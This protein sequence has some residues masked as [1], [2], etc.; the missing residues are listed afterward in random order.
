MK[1]VTIMDIAKQVNVSKTTVSMV[2][3]NK[4]INVLE[5]TRDK[6]LKA[7]KDLNYI[8]NSLARTLSTNRS[9]TIGCIV[10]DIEN[11]FFSEIAKAIETEAEDCGFSMILCNTLNREEKEEHY[12]K[13]LISKLV[14]GVIIVPSKYGTNSLD[15]LIRNNVPFVVVDRKVKYKEKYNVVHCNNKQGIKLGIEYLIGKSK[16]NLAFVGGIR[17]GVDTRLDYFKE[18]A[19]KLEILNEDIIEEENFSMNGGIRATEKIIKKNKNVDCIFYSSD[20]MA[21]GGIKYL[22]RNGYNVPEDISILGYDNIRICSFI[23]P[24]L[25]TIAQ[26]IYKMGEESFKL[27]LKAINSDEETKENISLSPYLVERE[28]VK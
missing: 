1:K 14:D 8:P 23:E 12:I 17:H 21:I 9:Y 16:K 27:L 5:E 15:L 24:E 22:I 28:T 11:P 26:P 19:S 3:N 10:P 7:A 25:T 6:I 13:L 2:L 4:K 18:F 20:V